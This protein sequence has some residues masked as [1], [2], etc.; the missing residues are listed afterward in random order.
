[1]YL[2]ISMDFVN[3][4]L[5]TANN[6]DICYADLAISQ[7]ITTYLNK[8]NKPCRTYEATPRGDFSSLTLRKEYFI[9]WYL[10]FQQ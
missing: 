1:M 8:P 9:K 3:I 5:N 7:K 4:L 10:S 2:A 6:D